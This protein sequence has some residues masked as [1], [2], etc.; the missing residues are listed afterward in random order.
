[1]ATKWNAI[2]TIKFN[3]IFILYHSMT[4]LLLSESSFLSLYVI[5]LEFTNGIIGRARRLCSL[6]TKDA[7]TH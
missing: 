3:D 1:M 4:E 2:I 7:H 5:I 6:F